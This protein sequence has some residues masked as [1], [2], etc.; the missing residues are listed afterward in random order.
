MKIAII[1]KDPGIPIPDVGD[2]ASIHIMEMAQAL[3]RYA[4]VRIICSNKTITNNTY[5]NIGITEIKPVLSIKKTVYKLLKNIHTLLVVIGKFFSRRSNSSDIEIGNSNSISRSSTAVSY[6]EYCLQFLETLDN[7]IHMLRFKKI[8]QNFIAQWNPD[9]IYERFSFYGNVGYLISRKLDIPL[10]LEVNSTVS[11]Y[12]NAQRG[13]LIPIFLLK[14]LEKQTLQNADAI[15][16]VCRE[17]KE[18]IEA[19]VSTK[20]EVLIMTN[21]VNLEKFNP[22][23]DSKQ[24]KHK[25]GLD[26]QIVIV[27]LGK[28][29]SHR[30][31]DVL[32]SSFISLLDLEN[33]SLL[34][35][36]SGIMEKKISHAINQI[37]ENY[38]A[39]RAIFI[40]GVSHS[41][42]PV[43]FQIADIL[44]APYNEE[45][46]FGSP[47]K[48]FEYM[49]MAKPIIASRVGQ[50]TDVL[51]DGKSAI[52]IDPGSE[53]QLTQ[54]VKLLINDES[55][56]SRLGRNAR[57]IV[58]KGYSWDTNAKAVIELYHQ[59]KL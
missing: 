2:A 21:K 38:G 39:N 37:R 3:S 25:L 16:A 48:I 22:S 10:I 56:R 27:Y 43:F 52:L 30:G 28:I 4:E 8:S 24:L 42:V 9:F 32:L 5:K 7:L 29:A 13:K 51:T 33:I 1:C 45:H 11:T 41:E 47:M 31:V 40:K 26:G 23:V 19:D 35:V 15:I 53:E 49:A 54:A 34:I 6:L 59:I 50:I 46:F 18:Q 55:L 44:V 58:E 12:T 36:G 57:E 17:L 14:Y 20:R